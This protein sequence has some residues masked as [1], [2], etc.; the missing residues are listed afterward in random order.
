M[1]VA[2]VNSDGAPGLAQELG[3]RGFPTVKWVHAGKLVD[4][5][6]PRTAQ[7]LHQFATT[8]HAIARVKGGGH[9]IPRP[10][11]QPRAL[12]MAPPSSLTILTRNLPQSR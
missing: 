11:P 12:V 4:Y 5:A 7:E 9:A 6:G 10:Q 3:I 2:A 1:R 8:Q